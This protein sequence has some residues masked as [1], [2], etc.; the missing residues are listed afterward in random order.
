M[1]LNAVAK[2]REAIFVLVTETNV[3]FDK[4]KLK[5]V[6]RNEQIVNNASCF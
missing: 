6:E 4:L 3:L 1:V 5:K 2:K